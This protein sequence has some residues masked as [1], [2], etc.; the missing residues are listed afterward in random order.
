MK[1]FLTPYIFADLWCRREFDCPWWV[2]SGRETDRDVVETSGCRWRCRCCVQN[3]YSSLGPLESAHAGMM[4]QF[5]FVWIPRQIPLIFLQS[6]ALEMIMFINTVQHSG[7]ARSHCFYIGIFEKFL[8][9]LND[10]SHAKKVILCWLEKTERS[11]REVDMW[12][13]SIV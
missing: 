6:D 10:Q 9:Y 12:K 4:E 11:F 5:Q 1:H 3:L 13:L 7:Q 8:D 2:H